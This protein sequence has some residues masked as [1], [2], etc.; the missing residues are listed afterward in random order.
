MKLSQ[1]TSLELNKLE[2]KNNKYSFINKIKL[3]IKKKKRDAVLVNL[4]KKNKLI[5]LNWHHFRITCIKKR[6]FT[7]KEM[8]E[9]IIKEIRTLINKK[10]DDIKNIESEF[11]IKNDKLNKAYNDTIE[12]NEDNEVLKRKV[13]SLEKKIENDKNNFKELW[14]N[15]LNDIK[16]LQE[17]LRSNEVLLAEAVKR[18]E[19]LQH[20]YCVDI[21]NAIKLNKQLNVIISNKNQTLADL[22][23]KQQR[24]GEE[25]NNE[26]QKLY[27]ENKALFNDYAKIIELKE[28][29]KRYNDEEK[30]KMLEKAK[31]KIARLENERIQYDYKV[32]LLENENKGIFDELVSEIKKK[33]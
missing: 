22:K 2:I 30:S 25:K 4:F 19:K 18:E 26:T 9:K 20:K 6:I 5:L 11:K 31:N 21:E 10:N 3:K 23:I 13:I 33:K 7:E 8:Y 12:L 32:K 27:K 1:N 15:N 14:N 28:K 24:S 29:E 17:T 16:K